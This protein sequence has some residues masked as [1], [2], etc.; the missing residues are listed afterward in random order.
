MKVEIIGK[1][2]P[3]PT[4]DITADIG[5]FVNTRRTYGT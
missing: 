3:F 4:R 1:E 2:A 5:T